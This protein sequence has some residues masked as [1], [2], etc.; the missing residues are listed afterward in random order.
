[1]DLSV[2]IVNY[3]VKYFLEQAL[4]SLKK[5]SEGFETEFFVVDNASTD[6]S[7]EYIEK[8][9]P[10]VQI[11]ANK[12]NL[13]FGTANNQGLSRSKGKYLLV[14]NPDTVVGEDSIKAF[15]DFLE[16]NPEIGAA[17]PKIIDR[18]GKFELSSK[19][20]FPTPFAAFSKI[21]GLAAVFPKSRL[22]AKYSLTYIHPDQECEIDSLAGCFMMLR[23]E[24]YEQ[25]RGFDEDFFMYGEDIDWCYRIKKDG[26][27]IY[28]LPSVEIIH[29]KGESSLRS[30][31]D[32]RKHF[33]QAMHLFVKKHYAGRQW[34]SL[35]L[36]RL[37]I[38]ISYILNWIKRTAPW[39]RAPLVDLFFLN[40]GLVLGRVIRYHTVLMPSKI[41]LPYFIYNL[42]WLVILYAFG[43]YGKKK[44]SLATTAFATL[45]GLA[46]LYSFTLFFKQ[47]A[48]SRFV[49]LFT[50]LLTLIA[51]PGWRWLILKAPKLPGFKTLF[52]RRTLL[53]GYDEITLRIAEKAAND[54]DFSFNIVGI[55]EQGHENLGKSVN[56]TEIIGTFED[57]PRLIAKLSIEE[58]VFSGK[59]VSY[60]EIMKCIDQFSGKAA[61]KVIPETA[62]ES[63]DGELPF[64]ELGY[65]SK[66]KLF[67]RWKIKI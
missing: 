2:I 29:Y 9:L 5:A 36:I 10:W 11:I 45:A 27:K 31:I 61:F 28:Y 3:N 37:G 43:I 65:K 14:I 46:F 33:Y 21:T 67:S 51:L 16:K 60:N 53:I 30:D 12:Q 44:G 32:T 47:Y 50:G 17:G 6:G 35:P 56:G 39:L 8:N 57:A 25:T 34:L 64:L 26:W 62:L 1:M 48:F 19:R 38:Y 13:G 40:I 63:L 66:P 54:Q 15:I 41:V 59:S 4:L 20:G 58:V 24:V 7:V 55:L 49:L 22:F 52:R 23:R 42:S 18:E